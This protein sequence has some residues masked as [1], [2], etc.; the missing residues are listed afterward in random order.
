MQPY[1]TPI[2]ETTIMSVKEDIHSQ[3]LGGLANA[4]SPIKT[5]ED[6]LAA[7]PKDADTTVRTRY[8]IT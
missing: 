1:T 7:M 3:N 5:P 2:K 8:E 4:T 6:L